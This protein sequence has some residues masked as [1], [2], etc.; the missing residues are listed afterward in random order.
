VGGEREIRNFTAVKIHGQCQ[1]VVMAKAS[2]K[3]GK[4]WASDEGR[5]QTVVNSDGGKKL[6][7]Y[8]E[9]VF[10]AQYHVT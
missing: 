7:F 10:C 3:Q 6:N 1:L 4:S 5:K 9:F 8:V 2:W